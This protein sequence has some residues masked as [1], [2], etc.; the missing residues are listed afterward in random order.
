MKKLMIAAV[1][2]AFAACTQAASFSWKTS[3]T[4]KVYNPGTETLLAS[5]TAYLFDSSAVTQ[6]SLVSAFAGG[7][8]DL[9]AKTSLSSKAIANGAIASTTFS[10]SSETHALRLH[11]TARALHPPAPKTLCL[12]GYPRF[13]LVRYRAW[14]LD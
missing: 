3:A 9:S 4:G 1:V 13:S 5:A 14:R 12:R 7:G 11:L 2:I 8:L 10:D 6:S